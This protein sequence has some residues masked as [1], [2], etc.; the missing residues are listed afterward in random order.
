MIKTLV[1]IEADLASSLAIRFACQ[2]GGIISMEVHPVYVKEFP[3]DGS[4]TGAGWASRTWEREIIKQGKDEI[5][6]MIMTEMDFC[7]ALIEPRVIYGDRQSEL[8][9][10]VQME[11]FGLYV[12]GTHFPWNAGSIY[13]QL[14]SKFCKGL[15]FP[16]VWVRTL[17]KINQVLLLCL[18]S[19]GVETL[20]QVFQRVWKGCP[21]P[22]LLAVP[23]GR[24]E[25]AKNLKEAVGNARS[26]LEQSGC[27]VEVQENFP[28]P[29]EELKDTALNFPLVAV[30]LERDVKKDH[31]GLHWLAM[32]KTA[33]LVAFY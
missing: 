6:E 24:Y 32:T 26:V 8:L 33:S 13:K 25:E 17:R 15:T 1:S 9:K 19:A 16:V 12:E 31:P 18:D 11:E 27:Q 10:I 4:R 28:E 2:L 21:V 29:Q 14:H 5:S 23:P 30:G 7:P 22:L 3:S 20:A